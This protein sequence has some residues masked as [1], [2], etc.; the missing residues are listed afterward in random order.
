LKRPLAAVAAIAL[1]NLALLAAIALTGP[2]SG[3]SGEAS[4]VVVIPKGA[5][6]PLRSDD[7]Y[8]QPWKVKVRVGESVRWANMDDFLHTVTATDGEFDAQLPGTGD[9]FAHTFTKEGNHS[10]YCLPHPWMR[11]YV[12]VVGPGG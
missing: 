5:A 9:S 11:G 12:E 1:A 3:G 6:F 8:Y 2:G 4:A 7:F 10:Y